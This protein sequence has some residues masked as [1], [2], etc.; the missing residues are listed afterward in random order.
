MFFNVAIV[1][2]HHFLEKSFGKFFNN[3]IK[4]ENCQYI[5][6]TVKMNDAG[7]IE[8]PTKNDFTFHQFDTK[9]TKD[10]NACGCDNTML[11]L[12]TK[13]KGEEIKDNGEDYVFDDTTPPYKNEFIRIL[14][15]EFLYFI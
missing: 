9:I 10:K 1:S 2:H 6:Q 4:I 12:D 7:I 15:K 14:V 13:V 8:S 5:V 11:G 3:P